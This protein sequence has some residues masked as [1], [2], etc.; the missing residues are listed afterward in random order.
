VKGSVFISYRRD[1]SEDITGRIHDH[2][3]RLIDRESLFRDVDN[4]PPGVRFDTHLDDALQN[5]GLVLAIIGPDWVTPRLSE[6]QD[7]LRLEIEYALRREIPIIP[8]LVR[9]ADIP[10]ASEIPESIA[11][12]VL[13]N[14]AVV[15][16][17]GGFK[18]SVESLAEAIKLHTSKP[19]TVAAPK[20]INLSPLWR[21]LNKATRIEDFQ[22]LANKLKADEQK[23]PDNEEI[24]EL[25]QQVDEA[26]SQESAKKPA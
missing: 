4:I 21:E 16:S 23:Y 12:L 7:H 5:C 13:Y 19:Q 6:P 24:G 8:V 10:T 11:N 17:G 1:D 15:H 26:L 3:E 14:G 25:K 20:K 18:S 2:L 9:D 22:K